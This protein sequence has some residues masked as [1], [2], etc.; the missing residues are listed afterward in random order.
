MKR[1]ICLVALVFSLCLAVARTP[2]AQ[3]MLRAVA[4]VNDE[5]VSMLDLDMRIR[6]TILATGQKDSGELRKRILPQ[7]VR[8]LIDERLQMQEA[9]R[10]D[11]KASEEQINRAVSEIAQRNK[12]GPEEFGKLL[13]SRGILAEALQTQIGAQLTW[14]LLVAR[15]LQPSVIVSND[16]VE[17]VVD[18]IAASRGNTRRH[19]S[20]IFLAVDTAVDKSR[21]RANAERLF[22]QLRA[23]AN[24]GAL[25]RQFSE[26]AAA[27]RGGDLGWVQ[28][29]QLSE[30]LDQ[31]LA[32]MAPGQLSRPIRTIGGFHILLLRNQRK[33][34]LGEVTVDLTQIVF[35]LPE[36]A[37][38]EQQQEASA[39][40]ADARQR[41]SDCSGLDELA[42]EIGSPGS[43]DLGTLKLSD[44]SPDLRK[45]VKDL[46][47][48]Q[49]SQPHLIQG[50]MTLLVV[51]GRE[52][53]GIDRKRIHQRLVLERLDM[54]AR[55][56]MRDLRR[57][58]N[59]DIRI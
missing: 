27:A 28:E 47:I 25:A 7:I 35:A 1:L 18:R 32:R 44:L 55:R 22:E 3:D 14:Q 29:G 52:E 8:T 15:R 45:A 11:I 51:C 57:S 53:S 37:S 16:E 42:R 5:V 40:A 23:G 10:L 54:L 17:E 46:P 6:L 33:V 21:V 30:E 38:A 43:G 39:R 41:I 31:A 20:E 9:E 49:P 24:F 58:A 12:M 48:G 50:N 13:E 19:V 59:V 34:S 4:V 2:A 56:Y 26:S 36:G